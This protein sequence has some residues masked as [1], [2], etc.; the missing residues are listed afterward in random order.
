LQKNESFAES[1]KNSATEKTQKSTVK[2]ARV[3]HFSRAGKSA[4]PVV[5]I[6]IRQSQTGQ[7]E[8]AAEN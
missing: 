5:Q 7:K 1:G 3:N 6:Y 4:V 2:N 8:L